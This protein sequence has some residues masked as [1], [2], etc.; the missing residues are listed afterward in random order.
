ML[1]VYTTGTISFAFLTLLYPASAAGT[2]PSVSL[3]YGTFQGST[4]G[5]LTEFLGVPFAQAGRF[6]LPRAP[7]LLPCIQN[8]TE[9]GPA[10]PQQAI[11]PFVLPFNYSGPTGVATYQSISEDCLTLDIFKPSTAN[12]SANLPV[13][14]WIY[15]GGFETGNSRDTD[16]SPVVERSIL[17]G[18]PVIVV[19]LNYRLTAFGF[20]A[21]QEVASAGITN[22]GLRDQIFGLDWVQQHIAA[23]GGDPQRVVVGGFSAGSISTGLLLLRNNR[24]SSTLF[25]GAFMLSGSPETCPSIADGQVDYDG[26]VAANNCTSAADTLACLRAVPFDAFMATVN[27]TA[28]YF[29]YRSLNLVWRPRVDGDVI[30]RDP[31]VSV[32]QGLYSQAPFMTGNDDDEGTV[33][34]LPLANIT[35]DAEFVDY[36]HSNYFP[37]ASAE[38]I[39]QIASLYP[40]NPSQGSPFDTGTADQLTPEYKRL[41]AFQGDSELIGPRRFFL[42][43]ASRRQDTWSWLNKRGK[44]TSPL[45]A[46]HVSD[47]PIFF[48]GNTTE[49]TAVDALVNFINTLDPNR[50]AG[51]ATANLSIFWP[52]WN[53]PSTTGSTSLL[54]FSDPG[55]V[56]V[57]AENFRVGAI[58]YLNGLIFDEALA[59]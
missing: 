11:S 41:A 1:L 12:A 15:G 32:S 28:D 25:R 47:I 43:H 24:N 55:V 59:K 44:N 35:T 49:T 45:G 14:V 36:V 53:T 29:S 5:N 18:E 34:T 42:E 4:T 9:Y 6:E 31:L 56:N 26:L 48:P 52:K 10:C 27:K 7:A 17:T 22:L 33:F 21:G 57:T 8:A 23:F 58:Q 13:L 54:T 37:S 39:A 51:P 46:F 3:P 30:A 38:Q 40:D 16:V 20:L 2:G 19:T 50:S